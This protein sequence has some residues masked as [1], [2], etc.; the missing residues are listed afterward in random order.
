MDTMSCS[1]SWSQSI[2]QVL[3]LF[4]ITSSQYKA[5]PEYKPHL[6]FSRISHHNLSTLFI[7]FSYPHCLYIFWTLWCH[8]DVTEIT[9]SALTPTLIPRV[10]SISYSTGSPWQSQPNL[11]S[12][13]W[14]VWCAYLVT[15]SYSG[16]VTVTHPFLL[17]IVTAWLW[18]VHCLII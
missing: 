11:L 8:Y 4:P 5:L 18:C 6:P 12:T 1:H 2:V 10:L 16:G 13:W 3:S 15:V 9:W 17:V 7:I 14:P